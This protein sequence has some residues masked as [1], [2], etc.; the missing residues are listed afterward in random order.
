MGNNK[1]KP[2]MDATGYITSLRTGA[3][4]GW[5]VCEHDPEEAGSYRVVCKAHRTVVTETVKAT[6]KALVRTVALWCERCARDADLFDSPVVVGRVKYAL[7]SLRETE[8][9]ALATVELDDRHPRYGATAADME[10]VFQH[11]G[12]PASLDPL[13]ERQIHLSGVKGRGLRLARRLMWKFPIDQAVEARRFLEAV[14][15]EL[16]ADP[17]EAVA[18]GT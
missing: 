1:R 17:G 7:C 5:V 9:I 2:H 13:P 12:V 6:A 3:G 16:S 8:P 14:A 10:L 11:A 15:L 18:G 4:R